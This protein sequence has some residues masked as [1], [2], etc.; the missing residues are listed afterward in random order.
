MHFPRRAACTGLSAFG[1]LAFGAVPAN[2]H[3]SAKPSKVAAGAMQ[4]VSFVVTHGC[5]VA[6]TTSLSV[7]IPAGVKVEK[8]SGPAGFRGTVDASANVVRFSGGSLKDGVKGS[9][10]MTLT[11]P[12]KDV[13]LSFPTVQT[14]G[15][16]KTSW[17]AV[18]SNADPD[19]QYPAPQIIVGNAKPVV[20]ATH[21]H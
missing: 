4:Q 8:P 7:K 19:P 13:V 12:K 21:T 6:A 15:T 1:F 5:G 17:I 10:S 2:A 3:V 16:K 9:F 20:T 18:A 11:F 14:C